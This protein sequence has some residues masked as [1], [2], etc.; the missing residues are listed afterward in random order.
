MSKAEYVVDEGWK[1]TIRVADAEVP[2]RLL[3]AAFR[4]KSLRHISEEASVEE[5]PA[6][7]EIAVATVAMEVVKA[8]AEAWREGEV[9]LVAGQCWRCRQV[10]FAAPWDEPEDREHLEEL[11]ARGAAV[12]LLVDGAYAFRGGR[13]VAGCFDC[14]VTRERRVG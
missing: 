14:T 6:L 11:R 5:P 2:V 12:D 13:W 9:D 10:V 7:L 1:H 3:D 8:G 4:S